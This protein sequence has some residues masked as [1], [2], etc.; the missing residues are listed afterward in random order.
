MRV[1]L[2]PLNTPPSQ[3]HVRGG[4]PPSPASLGRCAGRPN[5]LNSRPIHL[6]W[7]RLTPSD[8]LSHPGTAVQ[9]GPEA[10]AAAGEGGTVP[11]STGDVRVVRAEVAQAGCASR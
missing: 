6:S 5:P 3:V 8:H 1:S 9:V 11:G 2:I 7:P 10:A 4:L